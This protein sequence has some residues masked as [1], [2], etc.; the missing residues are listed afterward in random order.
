MPVKPSP[1]HSLH[2]ITSEFFR[3]YRSL[4]ILFYGLFY[5]FFVIFYLFFCIFPTCFCR[6]GAVALS[7][8]FCCW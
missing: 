1:K 8:S 4:F 6:R 5:C 3:S 2:K 7:W